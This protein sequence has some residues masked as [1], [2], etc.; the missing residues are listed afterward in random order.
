MIIISTQRNPPIFVIIFNV[1]D[2]NKLDRFHLCWR[3]NGPEALGSNWNQNLWI[4]V[5][6]RTQKRTNVKWWREMTDEITDNSWTHG[7]VRSDIRVNILSY[8]T[9]SVFW[10][11]CLILKKMT[12]TASGP[13]SKSVTEGFGMPLSIGLLL[14]CPHLV[15]LP[16]SGSVYFLWMMDLMP[17]GSLT[18]VWDE[19]GSGRAPCR[20][21]TW[22]HAG[23]PVDSH[24][25][26]MRVRFSSAGPS[27]YGAA[28]RVWTRRRWTRTSGDLI[29]AS[30]PLCPWIGGARS[31]VRSRAPAREM[32]AGARLA[33]RGAGTTPR[34][35]MRVTW[36]PCLTVLIMNPFICLRLHLCGSN[37]ASSSWTSAEGASGLRT[38]K[39]LQ[40]NLKFCNNLIMERHKKA[41]IKTKCCKL[42]KWCN[43]TVISNSFVIC[44][45]K[46]DHHRNSCSTHSFTQQSRMCTHLF[47]CKHAHMLMTNPQFLWILHWWIGNVWSSVHLCDG[48][49]TK[50]LFS[51]RRSKGRMT[52]TD[53]LITSVKLHSHRPRQLAF[54]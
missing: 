51:V 47:T 2:E 23:C 29:P 52:P 16:A 7:C 13:G 41:A 46:Y 43:Q 3:K 19:R 33:E 25:S 36:S 39:A 42:I 49:G 44:T 53:T 10:W 40:K 35:R 28:R 45:T 24:R 50:L 54:K 11:F 21:W 14:I 30:P 17:L 22:T 48:I 38:L 27:R 26:A 18:L 20:T 5:R 12:L 9:D 4:P 31:R 8:F 32:S 37:G 6:T 34:L 15:R 1:S